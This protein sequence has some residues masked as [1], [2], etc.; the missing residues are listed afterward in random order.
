MAG[1]AAVALVGGVVAG[2]AVGV[3]ALTGGSSIGPGPASARADTATHQIAAL[4]V[5]AQHGDAASTDPTQTDP[6][7]TEQPAPAPAPET[8]SACADPAVQQALADGTDADVVAAVGGGEAFRAAV[9]AGGASCLDLGEAHRTWVVVNKLNPLDPLDYW[10]EPQSRAQGVERTSGGHMRSDV[11]AALSELVAAARDEGAGS[12]GVNSGFR[13]YDMQVS[14][15]QGH[16]GELGRAQA[17]LTSA[18]PGYSEHQT[19][20]AVDVVACDPTCGGIRDFGGTEQS[21]WVAENA[22]RFGFIV[23]YGQ[24]HT[25]TTGYEYEPWH[26]RFVGVEL[27][28]AYADGDYRT[29]EEFFGLPAAAN[30]DD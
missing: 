11:A 17:D 20:L 10:P 18:R 25:G 24:G 13:S 30:Y 12:I 28:T 15:Y 22:A 14:T 29:L 21:D 5:P 19:G 3:G 1:G 26:L 7:Q 8:G 16:V 4:P 9:A 6:S 27:A 23:R 2:T